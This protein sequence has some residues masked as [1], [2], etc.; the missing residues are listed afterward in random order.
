AQALARPRRRQRGRR[1][2]LGEQALEAER[3]GS[4]GHLRPALAPLVDEDGRQLVRDPEHGVREHVGVAV[5]DAPGADGVADVA[6]GDFSED[7]L[8]G[9]IRR[10]RRDQLAALSN[11]EER[12]DELAYAA[13]VLG[14][15]EAL[16][17]LLD[18]YS[19]VTSEDV[20]EAAAGLVGDCSGARLRVLPRGA[21]AVEEEG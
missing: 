11:V 13:T 2:A 6:G 15:A 4:V 10:A 17:D 14:S 16:D 7:D 19:A 8:T 5:P 1:P 3:D 20:R 21:A 9:A 12:A 18:A